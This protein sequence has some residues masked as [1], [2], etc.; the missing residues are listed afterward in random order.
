MHN[1]YL[2]NYNINL[3]D[4]T[5][6]K[7]MTRSKNNGDW[8]T[9]TPLI[10]LGTILSP[11]EYRDNLHILYGSSPPDIQKLCD[12]CSSL[13]SLRHALN[14]KVGG[15]IIARH[16]ELRDELLQLASLAYSKNRLF[17]EPLI[18]TI[19]QSSVERI[20]NDNPITDTSSNSLPVNEIEQVLLE[21]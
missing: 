2:F 15:L 13:N 11:Q 8:I 14:C 17:D 4:N 10:I 1:E 5:K 16:N 3:L 19:N 6:K 7:I 21:E 9:V 12:G 20:S 18:N